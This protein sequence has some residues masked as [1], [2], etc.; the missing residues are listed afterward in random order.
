MVVFASLLGSVTRR[1]QQLLLAQDGAKAPCQ[2]RP[3]DARVANP[4]RISAD[5]RRSVQ[6]SDVSVH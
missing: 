2:L 1:R 5:Q 3:P 4:A 6:I